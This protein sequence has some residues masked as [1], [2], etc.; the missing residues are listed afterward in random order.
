MT[1][2]CF[3]YLGLLHR[4]C[5]HERSL[6]LYRVVAVWHKFPL[7][8]LYLSFETYSSFASWIVIRLSLDEEALC[9]AVHEEQVDAYRIGG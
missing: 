5:S 1:I 4:Q 6:Y 9:V 2:N 3:L 8:D 7:K